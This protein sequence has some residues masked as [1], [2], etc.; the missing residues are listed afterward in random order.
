MAFKCAK[1]HRLQKVE[2]GQVRV[3]KMHRLQKVN[4]LQ[5]VEKGEVKVQ[6]VL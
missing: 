2:K 3:Q 5:K 6:K 1:V 4:R